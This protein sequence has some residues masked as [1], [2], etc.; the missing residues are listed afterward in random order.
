MATQLFWRN[1]LIGTIKSDVTAIGGV[2]ASSMQSVTFKDEMTAPMIYN[3]LGLIIDF[4]E[5]FK[6]LYLTPDRSDDYRHTG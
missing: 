3:Q 4:D 1:R 6:E 2:M 5:A